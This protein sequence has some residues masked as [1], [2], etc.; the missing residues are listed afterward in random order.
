ML[1]KHRFGPAVLALIVC[2][3]SASAQTT[4]PPSKRMNPNPVVNRPDS[5]Q[6]A[7]LYGYWSRMTE[8]DRAG[9]ALLGKVLVKDELLPWDPIV[10]TVTCNGTAT[11]TAET[12]SKGYFAILPSRIPGE[13]SLLGDRERQMKVHFEGCTVQGFL[14]GFSSSGLNITEHNLRDSPEIG[15]LT[16]TREFT[17]RGTA[18]STTS[19]SAPPSA[20]EHWRK[21]GEEILA[22]QPDRARQQL[23]EAVRIYPGFADAWYHLGTL[24]L[25]SNPLQ[26]QLCLRRAAAADPAFVPPHEQLAGLAVQQQDWHGALQSISQYLQLD[27]KGTPHIWYYSA[28]A[29]FQLDN[30]DA[31]ERSANKLLAMD[32]LHNIRNGEQLLAVI[33]ARRAN[34]PGALAHLRH[35]LSYIPEGPDAQLLR[36]QIAQL[37]KHVPKTN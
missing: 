10:V 36:E 2:S 28:L 35:C 19:R 5:I 37:E 14:A 23:Q 9:G 13:L 15:T 24:Q 11:Y 31:A 34:Y 29:N 3:V 7:G 17:A 26:A 6:D 27:P 21:A 33:L 4:L 18:M 8:Q 16:L 1:T 25:V 22:D 12:D 20:A 30:V 32:P